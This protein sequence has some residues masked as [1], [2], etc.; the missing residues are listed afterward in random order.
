MASAL[1]R[2]LV[3]CLLNISE[4]LDRDAVEKVAHAAITHQHGDS[5]YMTVHLYVNNQRQGD[6]MRLNAKL[7]WTYC[8][9]D[10]V[11]SGIT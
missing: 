9:Q 10:A 3:A 6:M 4:A 8:Y 5:L 2:R 7:Q 11:A 1:G